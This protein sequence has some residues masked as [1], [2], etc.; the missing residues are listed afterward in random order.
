MAARDEMQTLMEQ[1][2]SA[3]NKGEPVPFLNLLDDDLT[4]GQWKMVSIHFSPLPHA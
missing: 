2:L 4:S 3:F 1:V